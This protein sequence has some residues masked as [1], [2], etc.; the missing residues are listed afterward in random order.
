MF[1]RFKAKRVPGVMA[2]VPFSDRI[3]LAH[4]ERSP[5]MRPVLRVLDS[6]KHGTQLSDSLQRLSSVRALRAACNT[7]LMATG[8]YQITQMEP[9]AVPLEERCNA[10]RWKLKE[11][12]DFPVDTA[13]IGVLDVPM[14][15][16]RQ[17]SIF[18]VAA[19]GDKV[20]HLMTAFADA[21]VPLDAIDI[22]ELA[23]RNISALLEDENRGLALLSL[24][25]AGS[26]LTI[27]FRGELYL[28]RRTEISAAQLAAADA[29]SRERLFERLMLELQRTLDNFDRQFGFVTVSALVVSACPAVDGLLPYLAENLYVPV[30]PLDLTAVIDCSAIPE[31]QNPE[32]Q[33]QCLMSIGAALRE[34]SAA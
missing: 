2:I 7:S 33:A 6:F 16:A 29:E 12:V 32:R 15:G 20:G 18:A 3:D 4:V 27:T 1:A 34:G 26:L 24:G 21:K 28:T 19:A 11:Q 30:R 25:E 22:P 8:E 5:G 17:P 13:S 31:L 23:Q 14:E 10:V 9:P